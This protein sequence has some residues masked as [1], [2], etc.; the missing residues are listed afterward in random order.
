MRYADIISK[1]HRFEKW[2]KPRKLKV[3]DE[4]EEEMNRLKRHELG[5]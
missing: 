4:I 3:R 1:I 2:G 5:G